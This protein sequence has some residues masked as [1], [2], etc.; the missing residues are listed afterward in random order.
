M[1]SIKEKLANCNWCLNNFVCLCL[2]RTKVIAWKPL[3]LQTDTD[4]N[5]HMTQCEWEILLS[6]K[7]FEVVLKT[8]CIMDL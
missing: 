6:Y 3:C 2:T 7:S 1:Y 8:N 5:R 4:N